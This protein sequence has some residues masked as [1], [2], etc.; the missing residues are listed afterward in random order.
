MYDPFLK[1]SLLGRAA[2][3]EILRFTKKKFT[4]YVA[5]KERI[6]A[7]TCG[8]LPGMVLKPELI[9]R[10]VDEREQADGPAYRIFFS[11][12]GE[13]LHQQLLNDIYQEIAKRGIRH[14]LLI[15]GR[16]EGMDARVEQLYADRIISLGNFVLMGGDIPAIAFLEGFTRLIPGVVGKKESVENDSFYGPFVDYPEYSLPVIW[17]NSE[18]PPVLRSGNHQAIAEWRKEK[19]TERTVRTRFNWM[20]SFSLTK[21]EKKR[22]KM[23][24]PPHCVVLMHSQIL[25]GKE[26]QEG[27]SSVTP[28]DIHD[29]ARAAA[30]YGVEQFFIVTAL[31]DQQAIVKQFL[32]FWQESRGVTYNPNRHEAL[33]RVK[34]VGSLDEVIEQMITEYKKD[35]LLVATSAQK[36]NGVSSLTYTDHSSVWK[37]ERP[38]LLILGTGQGLA[39]SV[40][41]RAHYALVPLEGLT[42]YNHLSVRSAAAIIFDRWLGISPKAYY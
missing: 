15:P 19:A 12:H 17:K 38:I 26:K 7:P 23:H 18:V 1:N 42:E 22:A 31:K 13:L 37:Q 32:Y 34:V 11:P 30:T 8:D 16:Y 25:I 40:L 39:S 27:N 5:P 29:I 3:K 14:I 33:E 41:E 2:E 6:D 24:I 35:P 36:V 9:E 10:I 4:D 28:L 21:E 20:R